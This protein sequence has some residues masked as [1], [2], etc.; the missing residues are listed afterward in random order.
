MD[1]SVALVDRKK[2]RW[3][4]KS[5][6]I[7][8]SII[9]AAALAT[10]VVLVIVFV[11]DLGPVRPISR[12]P[13]EAQVV[14]TVAGFEIRHDELRYITLINKASLEAKMG[15]YDTLS[16]EKKA[17]YDRELKALVLEDL[18]SNYVILSLCQKY[19]VDIDS[20]EAND[21]VND[22]IE[23]YV[24]EIG[25]KKNYKQWLADNGLTDAFLRLMYKVGY[26]ESALV[27]KLVER[28]VIKYSSDNLGEFVDFVVRDE[29]YVKIIHAYYPKDW[30]YKSGVTAKSSAEATAAMLKE[31][32][33]DEERFS[34]MRSAIG[35][36]PFVQGYSVM[37]SSD[38]YVTA[39]Q[40]HKDYEKIAF[41]LDEYEASSVLELDEGYY[42]LMRVPKGRQEVSRPAADLLVSYQYAILK[43]LVDEQRGAI[44]FKGNQNFDSIDLSEME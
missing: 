17:E 20:R 28:G 12:T 39:G 18:K 41:E 26:L 15:K 44:S 4:K 27:D 10:V 14:G 22:A 19:G 7:A 8:G 3:S 11:F 30:T 1:K 36:A 37:E 32:K 33:D 13:E 38:F 40:M 25:G 21:Y 6:I 42:V 35:N 2:T 29:S 31:A 9:G 16:D 5:K 43:R 34:I 24:D 23:S